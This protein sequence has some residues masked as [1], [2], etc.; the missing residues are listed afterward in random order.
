MHLLE[1]CGRAGCV[2][3]G[4]AI[5]YSKAWIFF[6]LIYCTLAHTFKFTV[7]GKYHR[8]A[9]IGY[10]LRRVAWHNGNRRTY[11]GIAGRARKPGGRNEKRVKTSKRYCCQL[12]SA[13][14]DA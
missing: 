3:R 11:P 2:P 12:H 10:Q 7:P 8:S 4:F 1:K 14:R 13:G 9:R 5:S 6:E